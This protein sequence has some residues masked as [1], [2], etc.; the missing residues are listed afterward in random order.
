MTR[1]F[2]FLL[3]CAGSLLA[4]AQRLIHDEHIEHQQERM[5]F[6]S[7]DRGKF[8]PRPGFLGL[9]PLYWATWALHPNYPKTDLRPL[10]PFGP[11]TQ[12]LMLTAATSSADEAYRL[13]SDTLRNSALSKSSVYTGLLSD[14]DPLW[15]LYY[16][17]QFSP[18]I[19][20]ER[21]PLD[22]AGEKEQKYL[23]SSGIYQWYLAEKDEI[24]ERLELTR[25]TTLER[26]ERLLSYQ[27]L[28][29][30]YQKLQA[31][32]LEKKRLAGKY[33]SIS[34]VKKTAS[35]ARKTLS[36]WGKIDIAIADRI[37][38]EAELR[39]GGGNE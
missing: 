34:E 1:L 37:L 3:L 6:K 7:W 18:L 30:E 5:V 32:W 29:G 13:H 11:Q 28:L 2:L 35:G 23:V 14:L 38:K 25:S 16:Q 8:T 17:K 27:R 36:K 33:I 21:N 12:R 19:Y 26:G 22:G 31:T 9:N 15:L 20:P 24:A 39:V 4:R 10:G